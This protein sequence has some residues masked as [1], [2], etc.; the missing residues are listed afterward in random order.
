MNRRVMNKFILTIALVCCSTLLYSQAA[1]HYWMSNAAVNVCTGNFESSAG[2]MSSSATGYSNNENFTKTF[3]P[4]TTG[5]LVSMNFVSCAIGAGDVL[6]VYNGA[7]TAAPIL[8]VYDI[9]NPIS[10]LIS[11]QI[12]SNPTGCLTFT[13][14]SDATITGSGWN[15]YF[16]CD[17]PCQNFE[18]DLQSLS[19]DTVDGGYINICQ[20]DTA[21]IE[22]YGNYFNNNQNYVQSDATTN[23]YWYYDSVV[24]DSGSTIHFPADSSGAFQLQVYA[25]DSMGCDASFNL[26]YWVRVTTEPLF[27]GAYSV[28]DTVC[29]GD[30]NTLFY[31]VSS[32]AWGARDTTTA[33]PTTFL[34]DGTGSTPGIYNNTL[35]FSKFATG[36]TISSA[37]DITKFWANM[38]HSFIGDLTIKMTCPN[39]NNAILKNFPGGGGTW[40]GEACDPGTVA[41]VGYNYEWK[42]LNNTNINMVGHVG[43]GCVGCPVVN[44]SCGAGTG[45]TLPAGSYN[46]AQPLS[47]FIGCPL[48]G[49]WTFTIV[50]QWASDDGYLFSWGVDFDSTLYPSDT[51]YFDPGIDSSW[52]DTAANSMTISTNF[53]NN[54]ILV[55][56]QV[57][58]STYCYTVTA[59]DGFGCAHDSVICFF[60][61]DRCD[62][63]CYVPQS[64]A[65]TQNKV[66]CPGGADGSIL[67]TPNPAEM[68]MPWTYV[69]SDA[70]GTPLQTSINLNAPDSI[71]G[72]AEGTYSLQI[73]DGNGCSSS[74]SVF[75]GTIRPMQV[76]VGGT[77]KTSCF[78]TACDGAASAFLFYG[79]QPFSY[80]WS[81]GDTL[82]ATNS[83][84]VGNQSL[85]I[86][87]ANG[88]SDTSNFTVTEPDPISAS[89]TGSTTIC[90]GN[91]TNVMASATGGVPPYSYDFGAG[92]SAVNNSTVS[93]TGTSSYWVT[94]TD[95]N[96][97]PTDSAEVII[98]VRP[99]LT[100]S[101]QNQD[102]VCPGDDF[103]L[104][105]YA[106]GGDSNYTYNWSNGLPDSDT[107]MVSATMSQFYKVTL[108][109]GC[110]TNPVVD[111]IWVQV[112]GYPAIKVDV[113]GFDTICEGKRYFLQAQG[114]GGVGNYTYEWNQGLG[115]GQ[116]KNDV[117]TAPTTYSVTVTDECFTNPGYA[118]IHVAFGD[119]DGYTLWVDTNKNCDPATF[120]FAWDTVNT[121]FEYYLDYGKGFEAI[122]G[123]DTISLD[124]KKDGCQDITAKLITRFG[125]ESSKTYPCM[126]EVLPSPL[127]NFDFESHKPNK[128]EHYVDFWD[129]SIGATSWLWYSNDVFIND[130]EKFS[131]PFPGVET[132]TIKLV[133]S[134][135]YGCL[136]STDTDLTVR[137]VTT[138]YYPTAFTPN[139][140]G[141]NDEFKIVG[142]GVKAEDYT[143]II[144][145]RWGGIVYNSTSR[146]QGWNGKDLNTGKELPVGTYSYFYS[147]RLHTNRKYSETGSV[148]LLR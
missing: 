86:T 95:L 98:Y 75:V 69:W 2:F 79:T 142:E 32:Q 68:P 129:R 90:I 45:T 78:G 110:G 82:S 74:W 132:N 21:T 5:S 136:D 19:P 52:I 10:G 47:N 35:T 91:S 103:N 126:I 25:T 62:P 88:C 77:R 71:G 131:A 125:C 31:N 118:D 130:K 6:T 134:N 33:A 49:T 17:I 37:S 80:L 102:T 66:T 120:N 29:F 115:F 147:L 13:F 12:L 124:F 22:V 83:L 105:C 7:S 84:C 11:A 64:P 128:I 146:D 14:V 48:N 34:P 94:V 63:Q 4:S 112:G 133:V 40:L 106:N 117:P 30:T 9:T 141:N 44:M 8:G 96:N 104:I 99:P 23:Y 61:R 43:A 148:T 38:E 20:D 53:A 138:Y 137:D 50:D 139:G 55:L 143:L 116:F 3:C 72:L 107:V 89:I 76:V 111:S 51:A 145:D 93:P 41:G 100:I 39:G 73:I 16:S 144:Y 24:I 101:F 92:F 57:D 58:S 26:N 135:D 15:A 122:N 46:S 113:L 119:Y 109:D 87:D 36:S 127:A 97:C 60:V 70:V 54:S 114:N 108:T 81:S 42:P 85:I 65:F 140:D 123:L 121:S 59:L 56:P 28:M 18:I 1:G 27:S 67:T